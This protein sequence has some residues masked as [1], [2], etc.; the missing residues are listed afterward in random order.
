MSYVSFNLLICWQVHVGYDQQFCNKHGSTGFFFYMLS[1]FALNIFQKWNNL[2]RCC[3]YFLFWE[4]YRIFFHNGYTNL[5]S[6]QPCVRAPF[7]P[8]PHKLFRNFSH[9]NA[10]HC[11]CTEIKSY[12]GLGLVLLK[13]CS[14]EHFLMYF[15]FQ[16]C[17][18]RSFAHFLTGLFSCWAFWDSY[19]FWMLIIYQMN[20]LH[21]LWLF[22]L[23]FHS[24]DFS[25]AVQN[26]LHLI[27]SHLY[28]FAFSSQA[29]GV[30]FKK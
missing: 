23:S 19:I 3:I 11:V 6:Q 12:C 8:Y 4:E 28:I 29:F 21:F 9:F 13:G 25:L 24:I 5:C 17:V 26:L 18:S 20:I 10:S 2:V 1:S 22:E 30:I 27:Q 14:V 16:N 7:S 15:S